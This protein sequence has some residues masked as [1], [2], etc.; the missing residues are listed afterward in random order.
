[1]LLSKT[2]S[3]QYIQVDDTYTAQELV[4]AL[5]ANS[6]A[7]VSN[8]SING[9]SE[10]TSYGYF[11]S[12]TS[13]FPFEN[14]IVLTTGLATSATGPNSSLLSE[15]ATDWSGDTDLQQALQVNNTTNAT[16]LEFDFIPLTDVISFDY[17]FSSEQYLTSITSSAQCNYTDGFAFLLKEIDSDTYQ[18]LAVVPN[19]DIPVRVNTVRGVGVCPEA[20]EQ[21]FDAFNG[22]NHPTNYNGQTVIL[23][24]EADV[25]AGNQYHI[26]LVVADQGNN[27][28][29]SAIFLGGGSFTATTDLGLDRLVVNDN[30]LCEEETYIL[31]ATYPTATDYKWYKDEVLIDGATEATYEVTE[32]GTYNVEVQITTDCFSYG[33]VTIEYSAK[34]EV[35]TRS[36]IQCDDNNDGLTTFNLNLATPLVSDGNNSFTATYHESATD[37]EEGINSITNTTL[38]QNNTP[39]QEIYA[40]VQNPYGCYSVSTVILTTSVNGVTTPTP[41]ARCDE[42]DN[43]EDGIFTVNLT[44]RD[45]EILEGLP[46]DLV[47]GYYLSAEDA[48]EAINPIGNPANFINT[49]PGGQTLYARIFG[50]SECYGI[51]ELELVI[52]S[53]GDSLANEDI[54]LCDDGSVILDAGN[55]YVSYKWDTDPEQETSTITV[56]ETGNYTVTVVNEFGCEGSKTFTVLQSGRATSA[57]ITINDFTDGNNTINITPEGLGDYEYSLNG[58]IYQDEPIFIEL[59]SGQY[60]IYIRDKN[61]CMPVYTDTIFVLDYPKFFTPNGDGVN[62][63]WRIPHMNN[64]PDIEVVVFDRFG[65]IVSGFK[66]ASSGWDGTLLGIKLPATDYWF[67]ITLENGQ[68]I[69]GHFALLR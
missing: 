11:T 28:Y 8:I 19:T 52:Y 20:N 13:N 58:V 56:T 68:T 60:T 36:L 40:R 44:Q 54:Y 61:G 37:A 39:N 48:L 25:I 7:S 46:D 42:D 67:T 12:G 26:K 9:S 38:Y 22:T 1:M 5:V 53:Y 33:E 66:G 17:I 24:A 63:T 30:P 32:T 49:T 69:K 59:A 62:E 21:Y 6:C 55:G 3:A 2:V 35:L 51:A 41:I 15:G 10:G 45:D 31:D 27:L 43:P 4:E 16:V 50:G 64:R 14:G 65:K 57:I 23:K 18:N 34:P 29:D 47:L